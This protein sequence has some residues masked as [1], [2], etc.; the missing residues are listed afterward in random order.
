MS[1]TNWLRRIT[2]YEPIG[3]LLLAPLFLFPERPPGSAGDPAIL[4]KVALGLVGVGWLLRGLAYDTL[5]RPTPFDLAVIVLALSVPGAWWAAP[6]KARALSA[7]G[8]LALGPALYYALIN[9][10]A[11]QRRPALLGW[12]VLALG[13][14]LA[15][16]VPV[17]VP[18]SSSWL[19]LP[20]ALLALPDLS[21]LIAGAVNQNVA[22]GV[23]VL[24]LPPALALLLDGGARWPGRL[25]G[26]LLLLLLG[27]ALVLTQSR[28]GVLAGAVGLA[29]VL[30]ARRRGLGWLPVAALVAA[31]ALLW[32]QGLATQALDFFGRNPLFGGWDGRLE[33]WRRAHYA[34]QDFPL[35]GVG[36][37]NF[38]VAVPALYPFFH[39]AADS[40]PPHAHNLFLQIGLDLGVVGL[41]A[42]AAIYLLAL[43]LLWQLLRGAVRPNPWWLAAGSA[44]SFVALLTHG[45]LDATLWGTRPAFMPWLLLAGITLLYTGAPAAE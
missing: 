24:A 16:I 32:Q 2:W 29:T 20:A 27:A 42:M 1:R 12:L 19:P 25:L 28:G 17:V 18:L 4:L 45:L 8:A 21:G 23:L 33:L 39:F 35:T 22:A 31:G 15:L 26:L 34:L 40:V 7:L 14:L 43:R 38:A 10:P 44:G 5:S 11:A 37:G 13:A 36:P 6:D 41:V 9:W 3:V 30:P